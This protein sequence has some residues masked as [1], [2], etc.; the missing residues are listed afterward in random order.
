[1]ENYKIRRDLLE[2]K[3]KGIWGKVEEWHEQ[4]LAGRE[5]EYVDGAGTL[6]G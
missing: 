5:M 4:K 2:E 3:S 6:F 1:M